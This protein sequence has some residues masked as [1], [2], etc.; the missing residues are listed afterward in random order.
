MDETSQLLEQ[1]NIE[2]TNKLLDELL[3]SSKIRYLKT[4]EVNNFS[5]LIIDLE[6][7]IIL[8][9]LKQVIP[10]ESLFLREDIFSKYLDKIIFD[11]FQHYGNQ[12]C[13]F[14]SVF[15]TDYFITIDFV[16]FIYKIPN[17][18][19]SK[20]KQCI[21]NPSVRFYV[22]PL[23]LNLTYKDAHSNVVIVDNYYKTIEFFE[24]HGSVFMGFQVPKPYNIENH[25]KILL[26]RLFPIK[27][28]YYTYKNVQN[29]CPRGLGLQSQQSIIN[30]QSGHCLAWSLLFIHVRINN[31]FLSTDYIMNYFNKQFTPIDLDIYM[32]RY[33]GLLEASTYNITKTIPN[34]KYSLNLSPQEKLLISERITTLTKQYLLELNTDKNK[35]IINN[36]FEE[37]ISYHKYP[38]FNDIF[39]KNVNEFIQ[40]LHIINELLLP[41]R[42]LS[43]IEEKVISKKLRQKDSSPLELLFKEMNE[44]KL[45]KPESTSET[46]STSEL[47]ST[48]ESDSTSE[49]ESTS[50][51][52]STSEPESTS[53]SSFETGYE[54]EEDEDELKDLY[55][56]FK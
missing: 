12:M 4:L 1:Y 23:R 54:S 40:S 44:Y 38:Q 22:I 20:I 41:K 35:T 11:A 47:E 6:D 15:Y 10:S 28:Q 19:L 29:N 32:R 2:E 43:D 42:K 45:T 24:P 51:S 25:V 36:I 14:K 7:N 26:S 27:S 8:P 56:Q 37:L 16:D 31:L 49:P 13:L 53:E 17:V 39:F 48:S 3:Q 5:D 9:N 50:E 34:F 52:D 18:L 21:A 46:E 55:E 33:I 30:P